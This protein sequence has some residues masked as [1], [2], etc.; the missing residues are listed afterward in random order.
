MTKAQREKAERVML[1]QMLDSNP[2]LK[3]VVDNMI[4]N[5][6]PE[7][8]DVIKPAIEEALKKARLIGIEIG[9]YT[10][11]IQAYEKVKDLDDAESIKKMLLDEANKVKDKFSL[12]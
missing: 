8:A 6:K 7:L 11:L 2:K 5:P 4:S 12:K 10:G 3:E 9:F 1:K